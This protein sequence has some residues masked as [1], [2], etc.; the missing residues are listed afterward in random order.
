MLSKLAS[1]SVRNYWRTSLR[2]ASTDVTTRRFTAYRK[3][4][5]LIGSG[6]GSLSCYDY[7]LRDGE[8]LGGFRR[9]MRSSKIALEIS[10]DYSIGL[11]GLVEN[12]EEYDKVNN[13]T[14]FG[15]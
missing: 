1:S 10:I 15:K 7:F 9:F 8:S 13:N 5:I 4:L 6:F 2:S 11:N 3:S 12:S 14:L